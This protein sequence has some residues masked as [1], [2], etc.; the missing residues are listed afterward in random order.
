[1]STMMDKRSD[2]AREMAHNIKQLMDMVVDEQIEINRKRVRVL[3]DFGMREHSRASYIIL[4]LSKDCVAKAVDSMWY[5]LLDKVSTMIT[6]FYK[7]VRA[8]VRVRQDV[9]LQEKALDNI[10]K[11]LR[12]AFDLVMND[13]RRA[14][15]I[16]KSITKE[17]LL[18]MS[19]ETL[20]QAK[21]DLRGEVEKELD[22]QTARAA[23]EEVDDQQSTGIKD[24]P[25]G[26]Q[27]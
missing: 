3:S 27:K 13:Q 5:P 17:Y 11:Q 4:Q 16:E 15:E 9:E 26:Q 14:E 20:L 22:R 12:D 2:N 6:R 18:K 25:I 7:D 21:S 10:L 1:M 8:S 23:G 19:A 24:I